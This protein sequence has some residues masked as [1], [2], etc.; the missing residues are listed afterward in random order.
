M[1]S[2]WASQHELEC[3]GQ[4]TQAGKWFSCASCG[5]VATNLR[6]LWL[7]DRNAA[8]TVA[9]PAGIQQRFLEACGLPARVV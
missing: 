6:A 9:D 1:N 7:L 8:K 3:G 5:L 4:W 2:L